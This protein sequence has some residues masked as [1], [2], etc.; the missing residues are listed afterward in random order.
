MLTAMKLPNA[1]LPGLCVALLVGLGSVPPRA[2]AQGAASAA[3]HKSVRGT[4][5]AVDKTLNALNMKTDDGKQVTWRFE[6][7]VVAELAAFKPGDAVVVIYRQRGADKAVTAVAFPGATKMPVY[8]NTMTERVELY[9]SAMTDG[10][11][12][13]TDAPADHNTIPVG[14]RAEAMGECWCCAP[15]GQ[16]CTPTNKTGVGKAFLT[17]CYN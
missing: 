3:E 4:L 10:V 1:V 12:K 6:K 8:V 15:D 13:A 14:G 9:S 7:G 17:R 16:S 2:A 11:C 5:I